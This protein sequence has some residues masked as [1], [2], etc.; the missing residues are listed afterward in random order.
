MGDMEV[1]REFDFFE[2]YKVIF[3]RSFGA[4]GSLWEEIQAIGDQPRKQSF[5]ANV[6]S[7]QPPNLIWCHVFLLND[8]TKRPSG[9]CKLDEGAVSTL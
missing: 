8:L 5:V 7:K 6:A 9:A 4:I 3:L 2:I 1:N